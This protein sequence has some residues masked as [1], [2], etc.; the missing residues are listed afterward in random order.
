[1]TVHPQH[2]FVSWLVANH[3]EADTPV[4]DFARDVK[5]APH[6]PAEGG[7]AELRLWLEDVGVEEW[8]LACFDTAWAEY[9]ADL[10]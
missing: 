9:E 6:F 5:V 2:D 8:A 7:R 3:A 10:L 4:G 1:V